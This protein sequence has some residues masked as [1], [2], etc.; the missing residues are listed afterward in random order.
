M[1][2]ALVSG[3]I[4]AAGIQAGNSVNSQDL[5]GTGSLAGFGTFCLAI[6][7]YIVFLLFFLA[8]EP[9]RALRPSFAVKKNLTAKNAKDSQRTQSKSL[10]EVAKLV[11][12]G[13]RSSLPF[14]RLA[15]YDSE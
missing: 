14:A 5:A 2:I 4:G 3:D 15:S 13:L 9:I 7:G 8:P 11:T 10:G 12:T 6:A 1:T